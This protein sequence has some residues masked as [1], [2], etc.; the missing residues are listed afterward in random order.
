MAMLTDIRVRQREYLLEISRALTA[1]L[2]LN[3]V[4]RRI[5][6]V[7]AELLSSNV[8]LI[9]LRL[10]DG[11]FAPRASYGL[12]AQFLPVFAPLWADPPERDAAGNWIV[13]QIDRKV[14]TIT[15]SG[16][17]GLRQTVFIPMMVGGDLVGIIYFFRAYSGM[18]S[19]NDREMLRSFA[20]Q[21]AIAVHNAQLYAQVTRD[22]QRLDAIIDATADGVLILD[23]TQRIA[24]FNRALARMTGLAA[25]EALGLQHD[26]VMVIDAKRNG[27]TLSEA[28][29]NGWPLRSSSAIYVEGDLRKTDG[30]HVPVGITYAALF[31]RDDRLV[32]IIANVRD[33]TRLREADDVKNTFISVISHELKTP[34]ALIKG[35]AG[36]LRREDA[37]WDAA[38]VR[39]SAAIIEEEADRLTHLIDNLLDASRLQA[40]AL[41]LNIADVALD[42]L[43]AHIVEKFSV[44]AQHHPIALDFPANFP[45]VPA[46]A[47][48][49]E[50]VLSNLI[51]NAMKYSPADT[52]IQI[53]GRFNPREVTVTVIDRGIGI[54][55]E[56]QARIFER[57]YRV[58]DA[59]S[60]RTQGS[61][62]GLYLAKAVVD[63]HHGRIWVSSQPGQGSAFSF[64]LPRE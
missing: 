20:D 46:D 24:V 7:A 63:A 43:A 62:L 8:G 15:R 61:G 59:L 13:P 22:K 5:L 3:S 26:E 64:A 42:Q 10:E 31:D 27:L 53:V 57:F 23:H 18:F 9:V 2:D 37:K 56:E 38:T 21:A 14:A 17:F 39:D 34:V 4:L 54:P 25:D 36:T 33:M 12:P 58:D 1:Q 28:A 47:V 16:D 32:N 51:N 45:T 49:L 50:Q 60:R 52:P 30:S 41:K 11:S 35:Y 48:R 6:E 55:L 44:E 29:A 40:G 19:I